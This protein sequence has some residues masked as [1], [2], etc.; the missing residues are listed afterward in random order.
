M[1]RMRRSHPK[2]THKGALFSK[3]ELLTKQIPPKTIFHYNQK[4]RM[5]KQSHKNYRWVL[6]CAKWFT[7]SDNITLLRETSLSKEYEIILRGEDLKEAS[8]HLA[9]MHQVKTKKEGFRPGKVPLNIVFSEKKQE[10][11]G[12]A[13]EKVLSQDIKKMIDGKDL[14][15]PLEYNLISSIDWQTLEDIGPLTLHV[16]I[17]FFPEIPVVDW[18]TVTLQ[19]YEIEPT[20]QEIAQE[21]ERQASQSVR[22][23]DLETPRPAQEGDMLIYE[24]RYNGPDGKDHVLQRAGI[25][26][27]AMI[28]KALDQKIKKSQI[29]HNVFEDLIENIEP[30]HVFTEKLSKEDAK[31]IGMP[32]LAHQEL[33]IQVKSVQKTV[34]CTADEAFA[35]TQG[36]ENLEAY[37]AQVRQHLVEMGK[38]LTHFSQEQQINAKLDDLLTFELPSFLVDKECAL[39]ERKML[40]KNAGKALTEEEKHTLRHDIERAMRKSFFWEHLGQSVELKEDDWAEY[41]HRTAQSHKVGTEDIVRYLQNDENAIRNASH[42]LIKEKTVRMAC[43]Q[44]MKNPIKCS[45]DAFKD[46]FQHIDQSKDAEQNMLLESLDDHVHDENCQHGHTGAHQ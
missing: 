16:S 41:I 44:A 13:I 42:S 21:M 30:G 29:K 22:G 32:H 15:G 45:F 27:R 12:K 26:N 23:V 17:N 33:S 18:N 31:A 38:K 10:I 43:Q 34:P 7:M 37:R 2:A 4:Y 1:P 19:D 39:A 11:L 9:Q 8:H 6:F 35:H 5:Q 28:T 3:E 20:E 24:M 25:L 14:A 36:F 46:T 40:Q